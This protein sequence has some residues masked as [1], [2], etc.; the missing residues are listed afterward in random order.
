MKLLH[1]EYTK[2]LLN[3]ETPLISFASFDKVT[4]ILKSIDTKKYDNLNDLI[5]Q[6]FKEK[7]V[8]V[9]IWATW[10]SPCK[11][12]FKH[13]EGLDMF[14]KSKNIEILYVTI[15][16]LSSLEKWKK[17]LKSLIYMDIIIFHQPFLKVIKRIF[18]MK[19]I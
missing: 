9:D 10:C 8:F 11:I 12:E 2:S 6:K 1:K 5:T 3:K 14:L 15:D 7:A 19:L 17:P 4:M 18:L 13:S 16:K